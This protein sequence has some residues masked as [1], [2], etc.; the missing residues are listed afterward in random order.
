M[1]DDVVFYLFLQKQKVGNV[2]VREEEDA[3]GGRWACIL[4]HLH[5]Q[6]EN[7]VLPG[8]RARQHCGCRNHPS[9]VHV[10]EEDPGGLE[11]GASSDLKMQLENGHDDERVSRG[12]AS[13]RA[14]CVCKVVP[15]EKETHR[16]PQQLT[17]RN[18]VPEWGVE[19][20]LVGQWLPA[21]GGDGA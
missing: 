1:Y 18:S 15:V 13:E 6:R 12:Q 7:I 9:P 19:S 16:R 8:S 4:L 21:A 11:A 17:P 10:R 2:C 14:V 3:R 5:I 20:S